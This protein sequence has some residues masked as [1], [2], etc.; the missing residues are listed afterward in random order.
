VNNEYS[1]WNIRIRSSIN[2]SEIAKIKKIC[3]F[4]GHKSKNR[5]PEPKNKIWVPKS[6]WS[7]ETFID[8]K[9]NMVDEENIC[10]LGSKSRKQ[11]LSGHKQNLGPKIKMVV[12]YIHRSGFYYRW[13]KYVLLG[14]KK[15]KIGN[16]A[17]KSVWSCDMSIRVA[18]KTTFFEIRLVAPFFSIF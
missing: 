17:P 18:W 14:V 8:Q 1:S 3:T 16:C 9:F 12:W 4:R 10:F 13:R 7:C 6:V 11:T 15:A 5:T 2:P